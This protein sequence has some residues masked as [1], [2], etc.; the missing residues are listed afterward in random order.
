[1]NDNDVPILRKIHEL[2]KLFHEYRLLVPKHERF[3]IYERSE[4]IIIGILELI[5][6]ASYSH[7][8]SKSIL[9]EKTSVKL[10]ILRFFIRLMKENK[11]LDV[12]KYTLLQGIIDEIGRMLG[13][14]IRSTVGK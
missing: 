8:E 5:L 6:E 2:Y 1:M 11:S 12:K 4:N 10:N 7:K 3:P 13:G 9:L 14:W